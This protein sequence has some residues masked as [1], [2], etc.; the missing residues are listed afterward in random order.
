MPNFLRVSSVLGG[1][2]NGCCVDNTLDRNSALFFNNMATKLLEMS[3]A[4]EARFDDIRKRCGAAVSSGPTFF[5]ASIETPTMVVS[6]PIE[7]T[8]YIK[9]FGPP[10]KG[11]FDEDKLKFVCFSLGIPFTPNKRATRPRH[12]HHPR[13][14]DAPP[15]A[16][17]PV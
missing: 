5:F 3:I 11:R 10:H 8:E 13:Q 1:S 14:D 17:P 2:A 6:V 15:A 7:Y 9:R 12:H 4:I 16:A